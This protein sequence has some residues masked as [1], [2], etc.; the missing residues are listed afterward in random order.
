MMTIV[1]ADM[2]VPGP[3]RFGLSRPRLALTPATAIILLVVAAAF[4]GSGN[5]A[6]KTLLDDIGPLTALALRGLIA[7][8]VI[9]PLVR[10]ER[11]ADRPAGFLPSAVVVSVLFVVAATFQQAAF[12]WTTVTNAGF[13]VN[14]CT[15]LTPLLA[16]VLLRERP[17]GRILAAAMV[18]LCGAALMCGWTTL[19]LSF[20]RGDLACLVSA[21]F[22]AAWA[23]ALGRHAVRYGRPVTTGFVQFALAGLVL[24]PVALVVEEPTVSGL[25]AAGPEVVYLAVFCTAG[26]CLLTAMAQR[27]VSAS[28]A[29]L[30]L[31][32]ESVFGAGA[33]FA[34]LQERPS[35]LVLSGGA[36]MLVAV[37]I[38]LER[39]DGRSRR[40]AVPGA[41]P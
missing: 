19:E 10:F 2:G 4:W 8:V 20:N 26:A 3:R 31:S 13:L 21:V 25:A 5:I 29:V 7:A 33:A 32:L 40:S 37:V 17:K 30:V 12:Q 35:V 36:L 38:A 22:Y 34:F 11:E 41:M 28:V 15:I 14:A 1:P 27:L 39:R 18:T 23:I 6:N 24:S 16:W 9:L